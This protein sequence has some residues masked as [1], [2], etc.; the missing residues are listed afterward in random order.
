MLNKNLNMHLKNHKNKDKQKP[1][2]L[3]DTYRKFTTVIKTG[4]IPFTTITEATH[5]Y[6]R[7]YATVTKE[8]HECYQK[9][10]KRKMNDKKVLN[11][12]Y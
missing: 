10:S 11:I 12:K 9:I 1:Y 8:T 5:E 2:G 3:I 6:N 7:K 4:R